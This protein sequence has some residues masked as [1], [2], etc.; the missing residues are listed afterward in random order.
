MP[1]FS[2]PSD[3]GTGTLGRE[4]LNFIDF[5]K[6]AGQTYWQIL[7]VNPVGY[8]GSPYQCTSSFAGNP[9]LID[10]EL[11]CEDGLL[12]HSD[13][14]KSNS[15]G[16]IDYEQLQENRIPLLKK[17][18]KKGLASPDGQ[19]LSF[20]EE[21]ADWVFDFALFCALKELSGG[22][23]WYEWEEPLRKREPAAIKS[24]SE[25]LKEAA[26]EIIYIQY[27]QSL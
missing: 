1:L 17:A 7:P 16:Y 2:L 9:Y 25:E 21:N 12:S 10:L 5:L 3:Y 24:K 22:K 15:A 11:L 14:K 8:S 27:L 4:A 19:F 23:A 6:E 26:E 13:L 18:A 20:K